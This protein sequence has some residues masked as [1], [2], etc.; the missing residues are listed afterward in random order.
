MEI[1]TLCMS[2]LTGDILTGVGA[3]K[4]KYIKIISLMAARN[5]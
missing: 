1:H 4:S 5:V 3:S 2:R